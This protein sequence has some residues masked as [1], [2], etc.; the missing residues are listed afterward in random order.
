MVASL[1]FRDTRVIATADY[2]PTGDYL[3]M[4]IGVIGGADGPT[5]IYV[6]STLNWVLVAVAAVV[7][8]AV[9]VL[10]FTVRKRKRRP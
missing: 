4:N 8:I 2:Y 3:S 9:I 10:L 6:A 7:L 1:S 5:A